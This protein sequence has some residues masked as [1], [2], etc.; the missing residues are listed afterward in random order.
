MIDVKAVDT[1]TLKNKLQDFWK[2]SG[3]KI[4]TL[5]KNYDNRLG[6]PV[7]T[8]DGQYTSLGWTEW[9]RGF[10]YGSA[11]LQYDAT[12][13]EHFLETGRQ[14]IIDHMAPHLVH[15]GVHDHGFNNISSYGNL[16]RLFNEGRLGDESWQGEFYK[17]AL[18]VSGAVQ[19]ARWTDIKD[20][21]YIYSFNGPHSLFIDTIRSCRILGMAHKLGYYLQGENDTRINLLERMFTHIITSA[22]YC[23]FYGEGRDAYDIP[24]RTAHEIIFNVRDGSY[25]CPNAQQGYSA[26]STWMRGL[27]WAILGFAEQLEFLAIFKDQQLES[28]GGRRQL[29]TI[30]LKAAQVTCKFY[31]E[32]V[33]T[34]GIPYWDSAAPD[35]HI[36]GD[37]LQ[38]K[39]DPF[40]TWEPVDSSAAVIAA[41][42]LL[43]L[44][45][46]LR[47]KG[48]EKN[49]EHFW[50]AGLTVA[51]TLLAPPYINTKEEH[52][53]LILHSIYHR[54][55]GWDYIPSGSKIPCGEAS[56]WG[57][58][59]ARELAL[60]LQRCLNNEKYYTFFGGVDDE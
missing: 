35:L 52:Q 22:R 3:Q 4:K 2:T 6:A 21:G 39:A 47:E 40:N 14:N 37:Y 49:A 45:H 31:I 8:K 32:N 7:F 25:R 54:P 5:E 17:L 24:G 60:Y 11:I 48:Q 41:Q 27:A 59:H 13:D 57:D 30:M 51:D 16:L 23:I 15:M 19:A 10:Q 28:F 34:D 58:Y 43:R 46:Y 42:G 20:G 55:N 9:T 18:R 44:G 53:G 26:F 36:L 1:E 29:E 38:R 50:Q 12:A 56:M 33:A